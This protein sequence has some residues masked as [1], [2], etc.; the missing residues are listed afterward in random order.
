M[1]KLSSGIIFL[2]TSL[3]LIYQNYISYFMQSRC[4]FYPTCSTYMLLSL[5]NFGLIKGIILTILRLC[6]CHPFYLSKDDSLCQKI[7]DK[8]EY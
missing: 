4:R 6:K 8:S 7:K 2:L 3:I 1:V 5:R